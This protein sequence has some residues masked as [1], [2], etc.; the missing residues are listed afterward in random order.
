M[1]APNNVRDNRVRL[2][3]VSK[4]M[5]MPMAAT[6]AHIAPTIAKR[7]RDGRTMAETAID[8]IKKRS[9]DSI[10]PPPIGEGH[11][12]DYT[13]PKMRVP[14]VPPKPN[15]FLTAILIGILRAV[16]AQ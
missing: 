13:L 3:I 4:T 1:V 8:M 6:I 12:R 2:P 7:I 11:E 9:V 14:F 5:A 10:A 15:E 16:F